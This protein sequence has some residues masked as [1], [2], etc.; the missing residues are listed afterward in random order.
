MRVLVV[1][2]GSSS[3][4]L[5]VLDGERLRD[6]QELRAAGGEV[7]SEELAAAVD[8]LGAVDAIGHRIVHG[9]TRFLEAVKVDAGV[10]AGLWELA[11]L[12]PLHQAKSLGALDAVSHLRP[13]CPAVACFDTAFHATIPRGA[14]TY[15][16]PRSWREQWGLR[17]FGFHGLSHAYAARRAA[18]LLAQPPQELSIVTC[19]L[20]AG[21]SLAAVKGGLSVDTTMGFTPLEGLAMATR[22][23][24]VDPGLVLWLMEHTEL[25]EERIS[26]A[27]EHESGMLALAGTDDMHTVIQRAGLGDEDARLGLEVYLHRL[28]SG[29]A[30]MASAMDGLDAVVWTGGVGEHAPAIRE[31]ASAG[32]S[33]LGVRIARD[34]NQTAAGD[35][36]LTA[37]GA[38]VR[39]LVVSAREDL[40]IARQVP[41]ALARA[42]ADGQPFS[43][44]GS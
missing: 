9:G 24:S 21:A 6:G 29:I 33:F 1:N 40:E 38:A 18:E 11:D 37:P 12:A 32:L 36:E 41:D 44:A 17:R 3:L 31:A 26:R 20:G 23:G 5:S 16:L 28:R 35:S 42:A 8:E 30:A 7:D 39:S 25:T 22:S 27:L 15:A 19:H 4:K 2:A 43:P 14:A 10:I 13:G 34:L